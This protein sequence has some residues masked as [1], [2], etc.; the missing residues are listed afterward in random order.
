MHKNIR[1]CDE[2]LQDYRNRDSSKNSSRNSSKKIDFV[3]D[4]NDNRDI[5]NITAPFSWKGETIIAGRVEARDSEDSEV[6]FFRET[7]KGY[8]PVKEY[9]S[10]RLQDPFVTTIRDQLVIGGVEIFPDPE[11]PES[12]SYRTIFYKGKALDQ[13]ERFTEGPDRMKDIR[14]LE[15][16]DGRILTA[17]RPQ[18]EIGGRGKI[19]F[20]ILSGLDK[21]TKETI[22]QAQILEDQFVPEEWGGCNEMH[23]LENGKVG[24]LSHIA[25][26][27]EAGDRHYY[28]TCFQYDPATGEHTPMKMIAERRDFQPGAAKRPDLTD[29][30]FSGGLVRKEGKKA[31]LYCGVSDAEAH[32]ITIDDPFL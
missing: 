2:L 16:P 9:K 29:V 11:K 3:L 32:C 18:G 22:D 8:V 15:L 6:L 14:L 1:T 20:I 26:F 13:L 17:V 23:L 12:L 21:L 28:S 24:V 19:G 25:S 31:V 27:D 4:A 30:I 7:D 10:L 5:Y